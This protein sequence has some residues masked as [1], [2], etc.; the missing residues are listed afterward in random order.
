MK[1]LLN[2]GKDFDGLTKED[3]GEGYMGSKGEHLLVNLVRHFYTF[4]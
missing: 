4:R 1:E 2:L 3:V